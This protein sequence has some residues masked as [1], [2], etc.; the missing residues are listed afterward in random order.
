[1]TEAMT[2]EIDKDLQFVFDWTIALT[3]WL[4]RHP[5][6]GISPRTAL[7]T[8]MHTMCSSVFVYWH[9]DAE[10]QLKILL[11]I[12]EC[13]QFLLEEIPAP[14]AAPMAQLLFQ[15]WADVLAMEERRAN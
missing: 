12:R 7:E 9:A 14:Y 6:A 13:H 2:D 10:T 4:E 3:A 8:L 5:E 11:A 15:P 1:M